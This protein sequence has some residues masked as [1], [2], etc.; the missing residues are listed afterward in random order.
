MYH[1]YVAQERAI[2]PLRTSFIYKQA[3]LCYNQPEFE[4]R[5]WE[6]N[7]LTY[8]LT[9]YV[10]NLDKN[11]YAIFNLP[12][13]V[14]AVIFAY[15]SRSPKSFRENLQT[16]LEKE[17]LL[18]Q[19]GNQLLLSE[20]ARRFHERWVVGYGHS[21][22]A[23]HAV[24]HIGIEKIS[25][26]ASSELELANRFNS[27]TEYSQRYQ[28]PRRGDF[29]IPEEIDQWPSLREAYIQFQHQAYDVYET[30][31]AGLKSYLEKKISPNKDETLKAYQTRIEK[32]AFEDARYV[33][34]LATLTNLG[35]TGNGR[36]LRDTLVILLSSPFPECV[37]LA[38]EM[39]KEIS[40][41]LPTLLRHVGAS[42][43][44]I[45]SSQRFKQLPHAGNGQAAGNRARTRSIDIPD[46]ETVLNRLCAGLLFSHQPVSHSQAEQWAKE[47]SLEQKEQLLRETLSDLGPFDNPHPVFETIRLKLYLS[48]SEANWH[49][50]LRHNR[51]TSFIFQPPNV[52]GGVTIP[53]HVREAGLADVMHRFLQQ[54]EQIYHQLAQESLTLAAYCVTNA[55]HREI[56]ADL[57]LWEL[58][59]L[60]NLRTSQEAQ[61]DIR[62]TFEQI[63]HELSQTHP[64]I[65]QFAKRRT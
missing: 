7:R 50:L 11:V 3:G 22:V 52:G 9:D 35:M 64:V 32:M 61:W 36:A 51:R 28:R 46:Y 45:N 1:T 15:V 26:L 10:S 12:E 65:A 58:Y 47:Q 56:V 34:P 55:H 2:R 57:S 25:R 13:E 44:L 42:A 63:H 19:P 30:L 14:I 49:Q 39:E 38:R 41:C 59:H 21:S 20:T 62:Q 8:R 33:L 54:A 4:Y 5:I 6:G 29:Y 16:L 53:P 40:F 18:T 60:I 27:F 31:L 37:R 24:A 17:E 43:H 23:E 48:V